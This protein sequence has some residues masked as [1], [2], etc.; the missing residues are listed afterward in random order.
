MLREHDADED[1]T[2][3]SIWVVGR[4]TGRRAGS[5]AGQ[6]TR[7]PSGRRTAPQI[8]FLRAAD[9]P[10][11]VWL[12]PAAGGEPEQLTTLPLGAGAPVWSPDGSRIAF[13]APTDRDPDAVRP[14]VTDRLDYQADG[15]GYLRTIRKHLFVLD[16][17]TKECRQVTRGDWHAGDPA[18]SPDGAKLAFAAATAPDADLRF[19]APLYTLDVSSP[20]AE[21]EVAGLADG[22]GGDRHL[23][24]RRLGTDRGRVERAA[25]R[26]CRPVARPARRRPRHG[27]RRAA[28]PQCDAG[29]TGLPGRTAPVRR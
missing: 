25:R 11:Q 15:A 27:S 8:A 5:R 16:P 1:R 17:A 12:L 29:W 7:R 19:R 14:I 24:R 6:P 10:P 3:R 2:L 9:G 13:G 28:R 18:W 4:R 22:V 20:A 26:T 21:P 23:E